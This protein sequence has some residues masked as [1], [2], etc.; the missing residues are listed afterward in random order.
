MRI[1]LN[2]MSERHARFDKL[3][4]IVIL[5]IRDLLCIV[6]LNVIPEIWEIELLS[7]LEYLPIMGSKIKIIKL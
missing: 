1:I 4:N 7:I 6:G 2:D 3:L 5:C